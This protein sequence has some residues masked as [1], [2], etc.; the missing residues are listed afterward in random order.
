MNQLMGIKTHADIVHLA[1]SCI[2]NLKQQIC[3]YNYDFI[4]SWKRIL[5]L[6]KVE[7]MRTS[8]A[9][10]NVFHCKR[11]GIQKMK[12]KINTAI[13]CV[14]SEMSIIFHLHN[15]NIAISVIWVTGNLLKLLKHTLVRVNTIYWGIEESAVYCKA[16]V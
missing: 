13:Y 2:K 8:S 12:N 5:N 6:D 11:Y 16:I 3:C 7:C 1:W 10:T 15:I 4:L 14:L 9:K